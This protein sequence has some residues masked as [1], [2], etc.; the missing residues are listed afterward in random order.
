MMF[1]GYA[2]NGYRLWDEKSSRIVVSRD[3]IF[4]EKEPPCKNLRSSTKE[5]YLRFYESSSE[6]SDSEETSDES[7]DDEYESADSEDDAITVDDSDDEESDVG[8]APAEQPATPTLRRSERVYGQWVANYERDQQT[9]ATAMN[10]L[11]AIP[12]TISQLSLRDDWPEWKRAIQDELDSLKENKTWTVVKSVPN[13]FKAIN[14]MW[15]FSI[16]D[17]ESVPRYKARLVAK[18]CSQRFGF[19]Y[20]ETFAPVAK[21]T[22]IRTILSIAVVNGMLIHQM[23]V[24]TAFLNGKLEEEVYMKLPNDESGERKLCR[25][26]KSI[27]GLKQA[28]RSWNKRFDEVMK[29]LHFGR[30][31]SDACVY[32]SDDYALYIVLYVDDILIVGKSSSE[33]E[34]VKSELSSRFKMKDLGEVKNFLG[35]E[36]KRNIK[37]KQ[38]KIS[39]K[40]YVEK[41]LT[42]FGMDNCKSIATPMGSDE[43]WMKN[44]DPPTEQPFKALLGCLQ[45]LALMSRPDISAAVSI[46]SRFQ[47]CATDRHWSGLKRILRYLQGSKDRY[48]L[49]DAHETKTA[50][51]GYADADY[52]NDYEDRK[53]NSGHVFQVYGNVISW[54]TKRQPIVSL[55]STEAEFISLCSAA[56]EGIWLSSLLGELGIRTAPFTI[57]EDN[58]PCIRIAEE[59]REHQR[60]KHIDI[61]YMFLRELIHE[62]KLKLEYV[63]SNEQ[64]ADLFTKPLGR[65]LFERMLDGLN[66]LD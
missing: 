41:V 13:D 56:K 31:H 29:E 2:N 35:L 65:Q 11:E 47:S 57:Y 36:I 25:L 15:V 17:S 18:G 30:L 45:Y 1:V 23:D 38:M 39:Q 60:S 5:M 7:S 9:A 21:M 37:S 10:V 8:D 33:I 26:N 43:K 27:Y 3:V 51:E 4:D 49:Y 66:M 34:E 63:P 61:K 16:K 48:L 32:V 50:L 53:S 24:K 58:L 54:S 14:S 46:L 64:L 62:K 42:R 55:S 28:S 52:G 20:H 59:P 44:D 22:T 12:Q 6:V 19:D 40:A